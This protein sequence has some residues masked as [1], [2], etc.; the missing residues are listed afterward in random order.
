MLTHIVFASGVSAFTC[1][2]LS[3]KLNITILSIIISISINILIDAIGHDHR[4]FHPPRRTRITHSLPGI[5]IIS[6]IISYLG[7]KGLPLH[8]HEKLLITISG[9]NGGLSHWFLDALNPTGVFIL[10]RRFRLARIPYWNPIANT[11]L[12]L[13]GIGLLVISFQKLL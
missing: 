11:L 5:I 3:C 10:R 6:I 9:L 8:E 1:S 7:V 2:T 4:L 13:V 12:Q